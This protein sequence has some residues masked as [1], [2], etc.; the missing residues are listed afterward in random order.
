M[1]ALGPALMFMR[2]DQQAQVLAEK[3]APV[4]DYREIVN[5]RT[6]PQGPSMPLSP[7]R[8][9]PVGSS[10]PLTAVL[11]RILSATT[12]NGGGSDV[13]KDDIRCL[14]DAVKMA[15]SNGHVVSHGG[16]N[17]GGDELM[18]G[19]AGLLWA[20]MNIR[21][22]R[23]SE[24]TTKA[25][26]PIFEAVPSLVDEIIDAGRQGSRDYMKKYGARSS[27][28]LMWVWMEGSYYLGA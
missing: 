13:S 3:G 22:H 6:L 15:L 17:M 12:L 18:Y 1:T 7:G 2:L 11:L 24:D 19:R 9:S 16:R 23:F 28:P 27:L 10:C 26:T 25:L 4:P 20:I 14:Y 5:E 8:L 21:V